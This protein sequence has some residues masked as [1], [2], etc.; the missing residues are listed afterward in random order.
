[1]TTFRIAVNRTWRDGS[2]EQKQDTQWFRIVTWEQLAETCN[3]YL[4]KGRQ[5]YVEGR[6]QT[7]SWEGQ[8]GARRYTTEVV[9]RQVLFLGGPGPEAAPEPEIGFGETG[10]EPYEQFGEDDLPF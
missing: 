3:R 2:G 9:A 4:S 1:V 6:L 10:D 7:R 8:D 5:C